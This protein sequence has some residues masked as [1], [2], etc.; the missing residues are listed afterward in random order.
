LPAQYST[1]FPLRRYSFVAGAATL[2]V[3]LVSWVAVRAAGPAQPE[4]GVP[5]M[6]QPTI[7]LG[8][9]GPTLIP[10]VQAPPLPSASGSAPVTSGA[11]PVV[12]NA[13]PK[14][15]TGRTPGKTVL[16]PSRKATTK[17]TPRQPTPPAAPAAAFSGHYT[18]GASWDQGFI[19]SVAVTN[20]TG[21]AR[22]W[23][24]R[25]TFDPSAGVRVGNTWNAQVSREGN[26]FVL[27]GPP[28]APGATVTAGFQ[29]SKQ[30][31]PRIK[32]TSC[33]V[34][35]APCRLG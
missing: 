15:T 25:L 17:P 3:V 10:L 35:G 30:V 28:L 9:A 31:R 13:S 5:L 1:V 14:A 29:A 12:K 4:G 11:A 22:S 19:G 23:T 24:V 16:K 18:T 32:P 7:P 26:T 34:D 8:V 27:T 2:L 21:P 20:K 6:V 33:T